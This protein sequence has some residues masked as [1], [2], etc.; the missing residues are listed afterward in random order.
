MTVSQSIFEMRVIIKKVR[1]TKFRNISVYVERKRYPRHARN[2]I[3][4]YSK[5]NRIIGSV[6]QK[7]SRRAKGEWMAFPKD[8]ARKTD[9]HIMPDGYGK[10][11]KPNCTQIFRF[12]GKI[13]YMHLSGL[14]IAVEVC[15][16]PSIVDNCK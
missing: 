10:E 4:I 3:G 12:L 9:P 11:V 13:D 8:R 16:L 15:P 6:H 2:C 14:S 7:A 5:S 1:G